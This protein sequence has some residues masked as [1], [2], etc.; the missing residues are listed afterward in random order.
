MA[1]KVDY[2][3]LKALSQE[4]IKCIGDEEEGEDPS[5]PKNEEMSSIDESGQTGM[6]V[7]FLP[8]SKKDD[9]EGEGAPEALDGKKRKKNKDDVMAL[10]A[11]NLASK[12]NK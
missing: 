10:L 2:A 12:F 3:K 6:M 9:Q 1:K 5:L 8:N 11:S 7:D 4:M